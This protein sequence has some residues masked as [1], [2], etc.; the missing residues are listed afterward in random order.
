M[1]FPHKIASTV[2]SVLGKPIP[3]R[4]GAMAATRVVKV[5][6]L[7]LLSAKGTLWNRD[8]A[9]RNLLCDVSNQQIT[10]LTLRA[11]QMQQYRVE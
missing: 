11:T 7:C 2:S 5:A 1:T 6:V 9:M 8:T 3:T 4:P 10:W